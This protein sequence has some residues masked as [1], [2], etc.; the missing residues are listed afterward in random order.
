M[1]QL[2]YRQLLLNHHPVNTYQLCET[3]FDFNCPYCVSSY[4]EEKDIIQHLK[5]KHKETVFLCKICKK[6]LSRKHDLKKTYEPF[7]W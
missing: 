5:E 3:M 1:P 4:S 7:T 6:L 2:K